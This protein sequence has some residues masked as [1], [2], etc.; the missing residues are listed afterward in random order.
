LATDL[1]WRNIC[2]SC[3]AFNLD[4]II[5]ID[6]ALPHSNSINVIDVR[7]H[8]WFIRFLCFLLCFKSFLVIFLFNLLEILLKLLILS[9]TSR[10]EVFV[11]YVITI[12]HYL[13]ILS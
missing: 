10:G 9:L 3:L 6:F 13:S 7:V 8:S 11:V 1:C 2:N 5:F 12:I 4:L